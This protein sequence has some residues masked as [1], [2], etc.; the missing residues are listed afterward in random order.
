M[1]IPSAVDIL[2]IRE[3]D[4]NEHTT[5]FVA[6]TRALKIPSEVNTGVVYVNGAFSYHAWP[7]VFVDGIWYDLDPTFGQDEVDAT[8]ITLIRGDF[9]KLIELLRIIGKLEIRVLEVKY[10]L[11]KES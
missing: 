4:C 10:S 8:H 1:S 11:N 3:G 9:E 6:L 2:N 7:S 5:L